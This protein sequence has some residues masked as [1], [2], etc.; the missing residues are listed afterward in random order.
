MGTGQSERS[1]VA[2]QK[3]AFDTL[4]RSDKF[5]AW[6]RAKTNLMLVHKQVIEDIVGT[7]MQNV[8]VEYR[9]NGKWVESSDD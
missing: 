9:K 5:Q 4:V 6:L 1:R 7:Q 2:N 8:R 3:Q